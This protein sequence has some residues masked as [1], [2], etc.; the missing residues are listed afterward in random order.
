METERSNNKRVAIFCDYYLP[1][2]R[3]GG[4][5]KSIRGIVSNLK[6]YFNFCLITRDRDKRSKTAYEGIQI[7]G[8]NT[9]DD[10]KIFYVGKSLTDLI[11][12]FKVIKKSNWEITYFNSLFSFKFSIFPFIISR[13]M[14]RRNLVIAPRGELDSGALSIKPLKKKFFLSFARLTRIY[15]QGRWHATSITEY[16]QIQKVLKIRPDSIVFVPNFPSIVACASKRKD[17]KV[18]VL[19]LIYVS[20]ITPK[21]KLDAALKALS[22]V[23]IPF[24][25]S[26]YGPVDDATYWEQCQ[27]WINRMGP[28]KVVWHGEV[29]PNEVS[30][31]FNASDL[32]LF[33]TLGEN[34]GHAIVEALANGCPVLISDKTPWSAVEAYGAGYVVRDDPVREIREILNAH[35]KMP[36]EPKAKMHDRALAFFQERVLNPN[37]IDDYRN[38]FG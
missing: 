36:A 2:F 16:E 23:K 21:K 18:D 26:I 24:K 9:R 4:P 7:N 15:A 1:G 30:A 10:E 3:A 8:W 28:E 11:S 14:G 38:L 13:L 25:F 34:Y 33:P 37:L 6:R 17:T 35:F 12:V 29:M 22:G 19:H 27:I 32:L 5:V 31:L 20:R